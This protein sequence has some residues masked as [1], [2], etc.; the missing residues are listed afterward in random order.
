MILTIDL[1]DYY[2]VTALSE[3]IR[4]DQ[5]DRYESRIEQSTHRLL[6]ILNDGSTGHSIRATFFCLGYV[7]E[8]Y[9]ELIREIHGLGHEIASHGYDHQQIMKMS[10]DQ[11]RED[12]RKSKA[13]LEEITGEKVRGY[14]AP[15]IRS[16][17][18]PSG[19]WKFLWKKASSTTPV[20]S[21]CITIFTAFRMHPVLPS[22]SQPTETETCSSSHWNGTPTFQT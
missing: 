1:E 18:K 22:L 10:P 16:R 2:M 17:E 21:R 7:A 15:A 19:P 8:R 5:W 14:R 3:V 12:I 20:Y 11:F 9:P 6:E 13:I 4:R